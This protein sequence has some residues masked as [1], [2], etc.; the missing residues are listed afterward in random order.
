MA[1]PVHADGLSSPA[2]TGLACNRCGHGWYQHTAGPCTLHTCGCPHFFWVDPVS[3][4]PT[5]Y[6]RP[7]GR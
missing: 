1:D 2:G 3:D 5:Y 4:R 6:R 7:P